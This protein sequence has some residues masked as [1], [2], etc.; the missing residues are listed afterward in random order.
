MKIRQ[1]GKEGKSSCEVLEVSA[2]EGLIS[3]PNW[4]PC[5]CDELCVGSKVEEFEL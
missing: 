5:Q 4:I 2:G 1:T 3:F